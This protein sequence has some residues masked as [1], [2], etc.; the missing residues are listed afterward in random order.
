MKAKIKVI[1]FAGISVYVHWTLAIALIALFGWLV[2][3]GRSLT[4]AF[5]GLVATTMLL[6]CVVLHEYGHALAARTFGVSTRN[7]TLY[8]FGGIALLERMPQEPRQELIIALAGP[9]VNLSIA[10]VLFVLG[11][12][13]G[14]LQSAGFVVHDTTGGL[15]LGPT[16][17]WWNLLLVLFN[18]IPAFPMDGGRVLRAA[19]ASR[20]S[21]RAATRIACYVAQG[22]ALVFALGAIFPNPVIPRFSPVLLFIALF[23]FAAA[24]QEASQVLNADKAN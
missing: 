21:Y 14:W 1:R 4:M 13:G 15:A 16:L 24:R 20:L 12:V 17:L 7:I 9:V 22:L 2:W 8:P 10:G 23:V 18:L 5:D 3:Q 6:M 19:L 11:L